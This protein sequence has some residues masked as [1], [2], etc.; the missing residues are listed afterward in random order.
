VLDGAALAG[1]SLS[2]SNLEEVRGR[3]TVRGGHARRMSLPHL[4]LAGTTVTSPSIGMSVTLTAFIAPRPDRPY[5][6]VA[7]GA[8]DAPALA[9]VGGTLELRNASDPGVTLKPLAFEYGLDA[10]TAAG[11]VAIHNEACQRSNL[12]GLRGLTSVPGDVTFR[13]VRSEIHGGVLDHLTTVEGSVTLQANNM[14]ELGP[15]PALVRVGR[16][17]TI[18]PAAPN[19]D[20]SSGGT[21]PRIPYPILE[22]LQQVGGDFVLEHTEVD[23]TTRD[24]F[25]RL[26]VVAGAFRI[27]G[28]SGPGATLGATGGAAPFTVG[29]IDFTAT[30]LER[31]PFHTDARVA[32]GATVVIRDNARLCQCEV[33]AFL[34]V[35]ALPV[36]AMT[37]GNGASASCTPCQA[38]SGCL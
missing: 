14:L 13:S 12:L 6:E 38:P 9:R 34:R 21:G 24:F 32:S 10:V 36:T 4:R 31:L 33:E 29:G 22:N 2:V 30:G 1:G 37:C 35:R 23:S 26:A 7:L 11:G 27:T 19:P 5:G 18:Q 17:L 3:L 8:L 15:L 16:H 25:P 20:C 28:P